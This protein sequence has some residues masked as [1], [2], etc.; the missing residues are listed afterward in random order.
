MNNMWLNTFFVKARLLVPSIA[1]INQLRKEK[2]VIYHIK[3]HPDGY[4]VTIRKGE[5]K[6]LAGSY[7]IVSIHSIYPAMIKFIFP[8]ITICFFL[9]ILMSY[10]PIGFVIEGNLNAVEEAELEELLDQHFLRIGPFEFLKSDL[11]VIEQQLRAYY[12]DYVWFNINRRGSNIVVSVYDVPSDEELDVENATDTLY[13]KRSGVI[14]KVNAKSCRVV[15]EVG[16]LV[17]VGDPLISCSVQ[18]PS[19]S[20]EIIPIDDI[21]VG[22]VWAETW[23]DVTLTFP[24]QFF[25]EMLTTRIQR[26]Y[27]LNIGNWQLA[28]PRRE[29]VFEDYEAHIKTYD[30]FFFL[31]QSPLFLE[32]IHYY[33]KS[34]IMKINDVEE[35]QNNVDALIKNEF[36]KQTDDE[37]IINKLEIISVD[38]KD[39]ETMLRYHVTILEDIAN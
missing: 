39:N 26:S 36:A 15:V 34:D 8:V 28:F 32:K 22:E 18:H 29:L 24:K 4:L 5:E 3:K 20:E 37:F 33:E 31:K 14:K 23:Y 19:G 2:V 6:K 9:I 16:Q 25:E 7:S 21:A 12:N 1:E 11:T 17:K 10:H 38:E 27:V 30:L 13:A 35:I